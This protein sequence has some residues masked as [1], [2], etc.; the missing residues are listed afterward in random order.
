MVT[1]IDA[2]GNESAA[3]AAASA[4]PLDSTAPAAPPDLRRHRR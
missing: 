4:T 2:A 3:S 1:A